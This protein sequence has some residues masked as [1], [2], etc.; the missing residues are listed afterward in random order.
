M[1]D[2]V[3]S[4]TRHPAARKRAPAST[5]RIANEFRMIWRAHSRRLPPLLSLLQAIF[6][7]A[8]EWR[9]SSIAKDQFRGDTLR[10]QT[11]RHHH[12]IRA[13]PRGA[14]K[15]GFNPRMQC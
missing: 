9:G 12:D 1:A 8:A 3:I 11:T 14:S 4:F 15:Y 2:F 6:N 5:G 13:R 7:V 10:R